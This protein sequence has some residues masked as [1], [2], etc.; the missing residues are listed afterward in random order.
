MYHTIYFPKLDESKTKIKTV[1][2]DTA[3][4][5]FHANDEKKSFIC[6]ALSPVIPLSGY[7]ENW[8]HYLP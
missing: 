4:R 6:K 7:R 1:L 8:S 2:Y 3:T 5:S